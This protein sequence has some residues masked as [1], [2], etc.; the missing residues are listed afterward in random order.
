MS[1]F[2]KKAHLKP[3]GT[4]NVATPDEL[5][6]RFIGQ[7][8]GTQELSQYAKISSKGVFVRIRRLTRDYLS[9]NK[10]NPASPNE[11]FDFVINSAEEDIKEKKV[12]S[13]LNLPSG[14]RAKMW[15]ILF[16]EEPKS[17]VILAIKEAL[18]G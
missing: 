16:V 13:Y 5:I 10:H 7:L 2:F 18:V 6:I 11:Y 3:R 8:K 15:G 17:P 1:G 9:A 4:F 12:Q 14:A